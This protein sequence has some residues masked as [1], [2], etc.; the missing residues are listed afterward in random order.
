MAPALSLQTVNC[1]TCG[2][3]QPSIQCAPH[4]RRPPWENCNMF[5]YL[6]DNWRRSLG[7]IDHDVVDQSAQQL[8]GFTRRT[9][10]LPESF[11]DFC[12]LAPVALRRNGMHGYRVGVEAST[13]AAAPQQTGQKPLRPPPVMEWYLP[14]R[15]A[16]LACTASQTSCSTMRSSGAS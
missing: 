10:A 5:N 13:T 2:P 4:R 7:R 12:N 16:R 15:S 6:R 9:F 1:E 11:M 3:P 14:P 8:D